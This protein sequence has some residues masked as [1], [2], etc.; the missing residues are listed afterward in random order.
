MS[1]DASYSPYLLAR[2]EHT[3]PQTALIWPASKQRK[4]DLFVVVV[5]R[6][7]Q[8][9]RVSCTPAQEKAQASPV[10]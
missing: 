3:L 8:G 10:S 4:Q 9:A 5:D 7:L 1:R 2:L 6:R